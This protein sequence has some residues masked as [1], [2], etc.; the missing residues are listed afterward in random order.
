MNAIED[1]PVR[2]FRTRTGVVVG[3][4]YIPPRTPQY[5]GSITRYTRA[6]QRRQA[7]REWL[8]ATAVAVA[9]TVCFA[10]IVVAV[11]P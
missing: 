3:G 8:G 9:A 5:V 11:F 10:L 1:R 7:R 2:P 4:A 6:E